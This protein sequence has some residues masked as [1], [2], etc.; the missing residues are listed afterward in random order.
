M[1][2]TNEQE[3]LPIIADMHTHSENSHDSTCK[4]E[5]MYA[6]Q[7]KKGTE[8]FAVTDHCDVFS[9][10]EYDIFK[11]ISNAYETVCRLREKYETDNILTG[12]E[13]GEAFWYPKEYEKIIR[14]EDYDVVIGSV[15]CIRPKGE[16]EIYSHIDFSKPNQDEIYRYAQVYFDDLLEMIEKTDFDILAHL[17]YPI[18]YLN[19]IYGR[20]VDLSRFDGEIEEILR[21]I[22]KRG[23]SLE[24][25][26]SSY[27]LLNDFMPTTE[28]L[29]KYYSMGG[30]MITLGSDAH[31][32][33]RASQ[34]FDNAIAAAKEIGFDGI[35]CYRKRK[36]IKLK[37]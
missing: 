19:G 20:G 7:L 6:A 31:A 13:I 30:R 23:S 37:F 3:N 29:K 32:A 26:T 33:E 36:P 4:I 21:R 25:N 16:T 14:L 27:D 9:F 2:K 35:Y 22:I 10:R 28:I 18:R 8:I 12:V 17:T 34:N 24:I 1:S 11:P 15:H 5:D